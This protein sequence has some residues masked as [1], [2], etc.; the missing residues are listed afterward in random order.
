MDRLT[1]AV[2]RAIRAAPCSLRALAREAGVPHVTLVWIRSG[3]RTA[4]PDVAAKVAAAL[5]RWSE[6]CA[7]G[8]R[9]IRQAQRKGAL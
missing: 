9:G 5:A 3:K 2:V 7:S 8:A 4:T 1:T 6:H